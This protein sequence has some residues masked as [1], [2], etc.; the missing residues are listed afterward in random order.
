MNEF[1]PETCFSVP[2][3]IAVVRPL[4]QTT[5]EERKRALAA[6]Y[7][8]TELLPQAMIYLDFKTDSGVSSLSTTQL[9]KFIGTGALESGME[10]AP[11][12]NKA[13]VSLTEEFRKIFGFPYGAGIA[14][15][16]GRAHLD[17]IHV[18]QGS[19]V[20]GNI[21]FPSTRYHVDSNG[22]RIIDVIRDQA[23]ELYSDEL[24]KGNIDPGKL[25]SVLKEHGQNV[26]CF[27]VELCVNVAGGILCLS[28]NLKAV[29]SL[30]RTFHVP[31]FLDACRILEIAV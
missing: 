11:G 16:S 7:Y 6:A 3:E 31:V 9:T 23:H 13:F 2:Y 30:C 1:F 27:Y 29:Q 5:R 4:R 12:G 17:Q 14:G 24:F 25:E 28:Q 15:P 21:L 26:A 10:M 22:G 8:N 20:A 19:V 18:K